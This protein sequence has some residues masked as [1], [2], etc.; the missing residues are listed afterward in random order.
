MIKRNFIWIILVTLFACTQEKPG[1]DKKLTLTDGEQF[2]IAREE[3]MDKI[4][5]GWAGQVIGCTYGGP[6][7][8]RFNGT[9][10]QDYQPIPWHE[11]YI[12][13]WYDHAPGLYDDIYMDLTFVEVF[14]KEGLDAPA[15][16]HA[17]ALANAE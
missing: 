2:T 8:F 15:L 12:K 11:G 17:R 4:K 16:S 1:R 7:E 10:I 13:W 9:M 6:T 5:G 3:L 14:E